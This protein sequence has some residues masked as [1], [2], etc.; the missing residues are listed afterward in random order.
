M[1]KAVI[2]FSAFFLLNVCFV[3]NNTS[4]N[5][6]DKALAK[7]LK[8]VGILSFNDVHELAIPDS[9]SEFDAIQGRFFTVNAANEA[10]LKYIYVGRVNSCRAG[11]CAIPDDGSTDINAEYFDYFILFD[12]SI[13]VLQVKVFN[14]QATHG[15]EISARGWLSQFIG[16]CSGDKLEVDKNVDAISG[17]TVSVY[18]ITSDIESK[19]N[20]LEVLARMK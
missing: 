20:V 2:I 3:W 10:N 5:Y 12:E 14:Y 17:A 15:H 9:L 6:Q 4:I 1:N 8:K 7:T 11:G 13:S 18:A 19:T 16:H